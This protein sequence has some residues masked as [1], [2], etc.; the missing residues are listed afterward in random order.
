[1]K[2][3]ELISLRLHN[4]QGV[5]DLT[6]ELDGKNAR[7]YGDNKVGKTTLANSCT[8]LWF[9][10]DN[11]GNTVFDWKPRD[12]ST[13]EEIHNLETSVEAVYLIDGVKTTVKRVA[14]EK[15]TKPRGSKGKVLTG[16]NTNFFINDFKKTPKEFSGFISSMVDE[17]A[18][19]MLT[20]IHHM[21]EK[22]NQE[23]RR[24]I[25][26]DLSKGVTDE[27][28]IENA[29]PG[30][31]YSPISGIILREGAC[32]SKRHFK[33]SRDKADKDI[34]ENEIKISE[35]QASIVDPGD[36]S[37]QALM[38]IA[39]NC[40]E[41]ASKLEIQRAGLTN[42]QYLN[43]LRQKKSGLL[44]NLENIRLEEERSRETVLA[45]IE[46][47]RRVTVR[48]SD[49]VSSEM[50]VAAS[51]IINIKKMISEEKAKLS[52][53]A[54][55]WTV[56]KG[57]SYTHEVVTC[58]HCG[59]DHPIGPAES[60]FNVLKSNEL[61][62]IAEEGFRARTAVKKA[63]EELVAVGSRRDDLAREKEELDNKI[64]VLDKEIFSIKN[65]ETRSKEH[66]D[67]QEDIARVDSEIELAGKD[68]SAKGLEEKRTAITE[69]I[70]AYREEAAAANKKISAIEANEEIRARIARYQTELDDL[71]AKSNTADNNM[72]L[73]EMFI[74]EK[75]SLLE[76]EVNKHFNI[77]KFRLF[78]PIIS[79]DDKEV[80]YPTVD[81]VSYGSIND[82]SKVQGSIDFIDIMS[83][84]YGFAPPLF[85]DRAGE[86]TSWPEYGGQMIFLYVSE[87]DKALRVELD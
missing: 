17:K 63:S 79:G 50:A 53:A 77:F 54:V 82:A 14:T 75:H 12:P 38:H 48:E 65:T 64:E 10:K 24:S 45:E 55:A 31:K 41:A 74:R 67:A 69:Q 61:E 19:I 71:R 47:R 46:D 85:V 30:S 3:M 81:G 60:E 44:V 49:R 28:I 80:C 33:E 87:Q 26:L 68:A 36:K 8:W 56:A 7:I 43:E 72:Y 25:L 34:L 15:W 20:N 32:A 62:S 1:M 18:F 5:K 2:K 40:T 78:E 13:W 29:G 4:F 57:K 86:V 11:A 16:H 84:F 6:I 39:K 37:L 23:E 73:A 58:P 51:N 22:M 70:T 59:K 9:G 66:A 27:M 83:D 76:K 21:A 52:A 35:A 42:D